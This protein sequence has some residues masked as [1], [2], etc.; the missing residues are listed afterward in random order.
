MKPDFAARL[1]CPARNCN[2]SGLKLHTTRTAVLQDRTETIEEVREG[3]LE[4]PECGRSYPVEEYVPSFEQLFPPDLQEEARYWG[5]W[6]GFM[7]ERGYLGLFD[8]RSPRAP[9][10]TEGITTLDPSSLYRDEHGGSHAAI[11]NDPAIAGAEWLLDIGCGTGWSSL[12]FAR[13]GH[14][15][16][17]IDPSVANMHLAKRYAISQGEYIEYMGAALGYLSFEPA[18]F[19]AV[20][21]LHSVHHVPNLEAE[22]AFLKDWMREG[23]G[24]GLDEHIRD[25]EILHGMGKAMQR[26][27]AEEVYPQARSL[28]VDAPST[29]PPAVPS[30]LEG[31]GSGSVIEAFL[32]N[33]DIT[34]FERRYVSLDVFSFLYYLSRGGDEQGYHYSANVIQYFYHFINE[35]FPDD[36]EYITLIGRKPAADSLPQSGDLAERVRRIDRDVSG[37]MTNAMAHMAE[38]RQALETSQA[39]EAALRHDL[40]QVNT[41]VD[42]LRAIVDNLNAT[43]WALQGT[44]DD[45]NLSI[46]ELRADNERLTATAAELHGIIAAKDR[47]IRQVEAWARDLERDLRAGRSILAQAR[48]ALLQ[49]R[50]RLRGRKRR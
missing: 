25:N 43:A 46:K 14:K 2:A 20:V 32:S 45:L 11:A 21:A 23:A 37:Q 22:I 17:G 26:W 12:Y 40:Q 7:W 1:R 41:A 34:H 13:H 47:H 9:L 44:V 24:I 18:T 49:L 28:P 29:L 10:I 27:A 31:A 8:L 36:A 50:T 38:M 39:A 30:T 48:A 4:C 16:A 3:S 15:V 6:Y 19:D 33:F 35:V 5:N 42:E